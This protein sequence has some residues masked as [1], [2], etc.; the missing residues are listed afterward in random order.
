MSEQQ[1]ELKSN[2]Q[3]I[4]MISSSLY[5]QLLA[6]NS[7][8]DELRNIVTVLNLISEQLEENGKKE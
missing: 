4:N 1:F 2:E 7:I 5:K 6:Q 8:R 3:C